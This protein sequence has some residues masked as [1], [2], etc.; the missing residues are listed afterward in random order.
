MN[1]TIST[2]LGG[3]NFIIEEIAYDKLKKY[4][5]D[6]K[7]HCGNDVDP[8]EVIADIESSMSEKLKEMLK[9]HQKV[10]TIANAEKLIE[11]M[12]TPEDFDRE[13]GGTEENKKS[14]E[15]DNK[16]RPKLYRDTDNAVI[17]GVAAG[18]GVYF[19]IDPVLFR[20][21][22][23]ALL[24]AG[25]VSIPLYILLWIAMPEAKTSNQKLEM[26]GQAPSA[27]AFEKLAR[28][29]NKLKESWKN[30]WQKSSII[31]K[32]LKLP[33]LIINGIFLAIKKVWNWIWP[34]I[35][36][37][38]GLFL[39]CFS[40][41]V[42][43]AV[44]VGGLFMILNVHS[45]YQI[46]YVP[47]SELTAIMPFTW[48]VIS[49]FLSLTI[50]LILLLLG[51][52]A[53]V[54][55]KN[56]INFATGSILIGIWM[57][58][59]IAC[60]SLSLRYL[61][62]AKIKA[63][64]YPALKASSKN[65]NLAEAKELIIN[66][67][68]LELTLNSGTSTEAV[69]TGREIDL[70]NINVQQEGQTIIITE[71]EPETN[72]QLCL[73]CYNKPINITIDSE[74]LANLIAKDGASISLKGEFNKVPVLRVENRST[75]D[76][77]DANVKELTASALNYSRINI[78]GEISSSTIIMADKSKLLLSALK[79]SKTNLTL[80]DKSTAILG[81]FSEANLNIGDGDR[82]FYASGTKLKGNLKNKKNYFIPVD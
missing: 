56:V 22:F 75:I 1:K 67:H 53:I 24:F 6:I 74:S 29:E 11:I 45:N 3:Q 65:I 4:L 40:L 31:G 44:G 43:G 14:E 28:T 68:N 26:Q 62:E 5:E 60:C 82:L 76:W 32:I 23:A 57:A 12:G 61:P 36:F 48:M 72:E 10:V 17:G 58:A 34:I 15:A 51:G 59:G 19:D 63:D 8:E 71:S 38:F 21:I 33:L 69:L 9:Q 27:A 64:N 70:K 50:P 73:D 80:S 20:V 39:I 78:S 52:I 54:G 37:C 41:I 18:L 66:G 35:K 55:K 77:V 2:N 25:G 79:G 47:I 30:R 46:S 16:I 81:K 13:I 42:L 7:K 49:G